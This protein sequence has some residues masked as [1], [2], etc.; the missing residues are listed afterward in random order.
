VFQNTKQGFGQTITSRLTVAD[1]QALQKESWIDAATAERWGLYRVNTHEGADLIGRIDPA[2]YAG[3]VFPAWRPGESSPR[4][5]FLRRD[6]P[7]LEMH[8][9]TLKPRQKYLAPPGRGNILIF[10]PDELGDTLTDPHLP[11][12]FLEGLKKTVA[13]WSLARWQC[14]RPRFLVC[15]VTGC[16]NWRG[17][18]GKTPDESG[19][20]VDLKGPIPDLSMV[21]WKDRPVSVLYDSDTRNN[22][23]VRGAR[24][25]LAKELRARG[26]CVGVTDLPM[27]P[28]CTKVGFD[29]L[30]ARW[31]PQAVL[32][33]LAIAP[34]KGEPKRA[35]NTVRYR[36]LEGIEPQPIE[37]LWP[38]RI[39]RGKTSVFA[40]H[41]GL[42][43]SQLTLDIAA[44]VS[45]G[46]T[47]PDGKACEAG[48]VVILS[49]EDDA[50]D[51]IRPRLEA[52]GADL[53]KT[54]IL[55]A[56]VDSSVVGNEVCRAFNLK[57]D[58]SALIGMVET[59]G[60]AAL[61]IIDPLT[62]YLGTTDSHKNA[63]VRALLSP[64]EDF[65]R[66]Q[67]TAVVYVTHLNKDANAD[68]L[69]RII[70]SLAFVA[71]ARAAFVIAIDLQN[72]GRRLF[73]PL[74]NNL[75]EPACGLAFTVEAA[76]IRNGE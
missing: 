75:A 46:R 28:G 72:P 20:R 61:I 40:G 47:W 45:T 5:Y 37:W 7:E 64:L 1:L 68:A 41:P 74:K 16:W 12:L 57:S 19:A 67:R 58:V 71:A 21:A 25:A 73:L 65:A 76:T 36:C 56:V 51:T 59:I 29:D 31:G 42:G 39:A 52:A 22:S 43:K 14:A 9:G 49:A 53:S 26:G 38:N 8:N 27:F 13:A 11:I 18:V 66:T 44:A 62:A 48:N 2:D 3:I 6:H 50:S 30:L 60:G 34:L 15:G 35:A 23:S 32:D 55:D 24:G 10:G 4:E 63:E 70:G 69:M 17:T 33:W 54:F